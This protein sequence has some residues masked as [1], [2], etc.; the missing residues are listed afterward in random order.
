MNTPLTNSAE[1]ENYFRTIWERGTMQSHERVYAV[2]LNDRGE[3]EMHKCICKGCYVSTSF[4]LREVVHYAMANHLDYVVLA[5]N[6]P[7]GNCE[8][9]NSDLE[10][11]KRIYQ[12]LIALD[13][14]LIDHLIICHDNY[15]SF[16]DAGIIE[17]YN[18]EY[19]GLKKAG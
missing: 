4:D 1:C 19:V 14:K 12:T 17:S 7:S 8:P 18:K 6:H 15:Y 10:M 11:T 2:Y 5:H 3:R 16:K 9:S 13:I